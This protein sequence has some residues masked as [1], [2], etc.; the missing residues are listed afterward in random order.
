MNLFRATACVVALSASALAPAQA[1]IFDQPVAANAYVTLNG[2]DWAW[3]APLPGLV[4]LSFQATF[5]WQL[6]T[7]SQLDAAPQATDFIFA[8]A[9]VPLF[10]VDPVSG[11][12]FQATN[13][14]LTGAA[15]CAAAYFGTSYVHCDWQDGLGQVYGPWAGMPGAQDFA[16]Q[17]V[18][19]VSA[20]PEPETYALMLG[21]LLTLAGVARCRRRG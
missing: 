3:A 19:R 10:G 21:G 15:A 8:G 16:D 12:T 17:L 11:S 6:P 14:A 20:V 9:N 4:D 1:A 18:V 13:G 2:L 5:G 7:A